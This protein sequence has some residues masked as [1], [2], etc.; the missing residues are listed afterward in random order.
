MSLSQTLTSWPGKVDLTTPLPSLL[1]HREVEVFKPRS[2]LP[3]PRLPNA[4]NPTLTARSIEYSYPPYRTRNP[5]STKMA[6][7]DNNAYSHYDHFAT[8][9]W[10]PQEQMGVPSA[11]EPLFTQIPGSFAIGWE[12]TEQPGL[13]AGQWSDLYASALPTFANYGKGS[14]RPFVICFLTRAL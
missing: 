12:T 4:A 8:G 7:P 1:Y 14:G 6:Y 9:S 3:V 2:A 5:E 13:G 11:T 10:D